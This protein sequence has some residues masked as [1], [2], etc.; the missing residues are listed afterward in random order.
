VPAGQHLGL[1]PGLDPLGLLAAAL[2][3]PADLPL[4]PSHRVDARVDDHLPAVAA[5]TDHR[6]AC[7]SVNDPV[8]DSADSSLTEGTRQVL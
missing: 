1:E 8:N 7:P 3:L 6:L 2:D 5:G 4:P